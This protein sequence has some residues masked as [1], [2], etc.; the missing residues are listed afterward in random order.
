MFDQI[1]RESSI[2]LLGTV[3]LRSEDTVNARLTTGELELLVTELEILG[4]AN[5]E[6]PFEI[7]TSKEVKEDIRLNRIT[8]YNVCYTKLLRKLL[9]MQEEMDNF[10]FFLFF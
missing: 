9:Q 3:R 8:S 4:K 2:T 5:N 10:L 7:M 1:T 6:L